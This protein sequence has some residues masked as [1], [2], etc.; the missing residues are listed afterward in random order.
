MNGM[1]SIEHTLEWKPT[2]FNFTC[3]I[4]C[5]KNVYTKREYC[6]GVM[7][8]VGCDSTSE[9]TGEMVAMVSSRA[10][11]VAPTLCSQDQRRRGGHCSSANNQPILLTQIQPPLNTHAY[12]ISKEVV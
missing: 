11:S 8:D 6:Y 3:S 7:L 12:S 5:K 1:I 9:Y 2:F 10:E 4:L